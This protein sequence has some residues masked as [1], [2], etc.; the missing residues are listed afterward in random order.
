MCCG[1]E[2][3]IIIVVCKVVCVYMWGE[4]FYFDII[5]F[6]GVKKNIFIDVEMILGV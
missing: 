4:W 5:V 2:V 1:S 3:V 6:L